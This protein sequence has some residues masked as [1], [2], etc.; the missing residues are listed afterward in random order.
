MKYQILCTACDKCTKVLDQSTSETVRP[1]LHVE[2]R[3]FCSAICASEF[4][5]ELVSSASAEV[6]LRLSR[7]AS[8]LP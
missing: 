4:Y 6:A 8:S 2:D 5:S 3:A 1:Y 7:Y